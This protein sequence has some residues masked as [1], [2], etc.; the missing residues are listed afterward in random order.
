MYKLRRMSNPP[1]RPDSAD[2]AESAA[3][4]EIGVGDLPGDGLPDDAAANDSGLGDLTPETQA[5][6]DT[7]LPESV[8]QDPDAE[9]VRMIQGGDQKA[10]NLLAVKYQKRLERL[11]GRM[12]R[13]DG[14]VAD[15]VQDSLIRAWRAI[16]NFRGEAQFYTWLYR[17]AINTAKKHLMKVKRD[18]VVSE[19]SLVSATDDEDETSRQRSALNDRVA[20]GETPES[21]YAAREIAEAVKAAVDA[22]PAELREAIE[23]REMEGLSYEEISEVMNCPIGTVR[24]RIF[25]AREAISARIKPMLERQGGKR[26]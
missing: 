7:E 2:T 6:V 18:P 24:S 22:L 26:W 4:D 15:I 8:L 16:G 17:I 3:A 23:L 11:V 5:L 20:E 21:A 13:D 9:L 10:Y 14:A 19:S 12:V 25:R 1:D